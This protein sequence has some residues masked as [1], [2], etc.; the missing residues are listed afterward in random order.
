MLSVRPGQSASD[1]VYKFST[2]QYLLDIYPNAAVAYSLRKLRSV[3]SGSA[4]RIRRSGDNA[5]TDIGFTALNNF[6]TASAE[7]FCIAGGGTQNGYVTTFYDQ[8]GNSKNAT[9]A[10]ASQQPII[11]SSGAVVT[12]GSK[13]TV[14]FDGSD[15]FL[16]ASYRATTQIITVLGVQQFLTTANNQVGI[17]VS[18]ISSGQIYFGYITSGATSYTYEDTQ[19]KTRTNTTNRQLVT[20]AIG[21]ANG[22]WYVNG[23][24]SGFT[25]DNTITQITQ[26][27]GQDLRLG[28]YS[29]GGFNANINIQEFII[30]Q[31]DQS[32]NITGLELNINTYYGIY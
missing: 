29:G 12:T 31:I 13:P 1:S 8:S 28:G 17:T 24:G 9:N 14:Q 30:F 7:A 25:P 3:Y 10:T 26:T 2:Y 19:S 15:D 4:V 21:G 32:A 20:L 16:S 11:V 6:D 5:E 18:E 27:S 22:N 23:S